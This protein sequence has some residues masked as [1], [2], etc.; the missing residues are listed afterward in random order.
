MTDSRPRRRWL[1]LVVVLVPASALIVLLGFGLRNAAGP[2]APGD[3]APA[4]RAPLLAGDG[5]L[6]LSELRGEPVVLNFWASWCEPCADEAPMLR[7]AHR[8]YGDEI[9]FVGVDIRDDEGDALEF[10]AEHD[11]DFWHVRDEDLSIYDDYGLTGQPETFFL[12]SDG[13][14]V[15]HVNGPL[16]EDDLVA[17]LDDLSK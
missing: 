3:P 5:S 14:I 7:R 1:R 15:E 13:T 16:F 12:D 17:L 11:L 2:P 4:F 6:D 9:A 8:E 10:V